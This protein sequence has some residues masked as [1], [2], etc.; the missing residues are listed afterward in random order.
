MFPFIRVC[1]RLPI[2]SVG[3]FMLM[4]PCMSR[5]M[6]YEAH[7]TVASSNVVHGDACSGLKPNRCSAKLGCDWFDNSCGARIAWLHVMKCGSSFGT[8][9]AHF[10]NTSL[11]ET[12]H[13][14]S[15]ENMSDPEDTIKEG[16]QGEPN[17]LGSSIQLGSGSQ[18]YSGIRVTQEITSP[19]C[20]MSGRSGSTVGSEF[21]ANQQ[22]ELCLPITILVIRRE[23]C[24]RTCEKSR[25]NKLACCRLEHLEWR[26]LNVNSIEKDQTK[27]ANALPL[28]T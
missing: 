5:A 26:G 21:S 7:Q 13:I 1:T 22:V 16:L 18:T 19:F 8:T 4:T 15:G 25:A 6:L 17:F 2:M 10:A 23:I 11:P 3:L 9:L 28:Q 14:P 24:L 27:R 20:G 12:A